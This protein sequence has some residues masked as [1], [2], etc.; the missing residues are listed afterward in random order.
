MSAGFFI[1]GVMSGAIVWLAFRFFDR[2]R[3][4]SVREF[5]E[6]Q[7]AIFEDQNRLQ[8]LK[9]E[10]FQNLKAKRDAGTKSTFGK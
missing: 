5:A 4:R 7:D 1:L 3:E 9:H 6:R 2:R 8:A 10:P